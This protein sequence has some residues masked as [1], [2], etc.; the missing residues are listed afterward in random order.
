M[1]TAIALPTNATSPDYDSSFGL[2]PANA[3]W[4]MLAE[5]EIEIDW[6]F[7]VPPA[8]KAN[9][10]A[11]VDSAITAARFGVAML[12]SPQ[13]LVDQASDDVLRKWADRLSLDRCSN[14]DQVWFVWL[15][16]NSNQRRSLNPFLF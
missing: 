2:N 7:A 3:L 14:T 1:T 4:E 6:V 12:L 10:A 13:F 8:N 5:E 9:A 11:I 16:A 15:A